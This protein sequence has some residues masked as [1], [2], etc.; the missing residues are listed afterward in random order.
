MRQFGVNFVYFFVY[1]DNRLVCRCRVKAQYARHLYVKKP[2]KVFIGYRAYQFGGKCFD[3]LA[4][5]A[6]RSL[7]RLACLKLLVL[8][9]ALFNE[10]TLQGGE[11]QR[12][13]SL[14]KL[15]FKLCLENVAGSVD[16][17]AQNIA[18]SDKMRLVVV[19]HTAVRRNGKLAVGKG[20]QGIDSLVAGNTCL[21]INH[22]KSGSRRVVIDLTYLYLS[23][24]VGFQYR[25]NKAAACN[26]VRKFRYCQC[27]VVNLFYFRSYSDPASAGTVI[28]TAHINESARREIGVQFEV[29]ALE[30]GNRRV[31]YF[32]EIVRQY[33]A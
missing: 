13:T 12:F 20:V 31:N 6:Y 14:A 8:I 19:N 29:L 16:I 11:M 22:H 15:Y 2:E 30:K 1:G 18:Y 17:T 25:F 9:Y 32:V 3:A 28:I 26:T 24:F 5:V 23:F 21:K 27:A 10:Y 33:K 7:L 4:N